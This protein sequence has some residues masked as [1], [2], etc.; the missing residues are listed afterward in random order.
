LRTITFKLKAVIWYLKRPRL[1]PQLIRKTASKLFLSKSPDTRKEA[2]HLCREKAITSSDA[3]ARITGVAMPEPIQTKYKDIFAAA[4]AAAGKCPV[5]M[6]SPGDLNI[7][8]WIAEHLKARNVVETGVA[9]GWSSLAILLSISKRK[10]SLLVSTDMPYLNLN[11]DRYVGCVVPS[12]LKRHWQIIPLADRDAIPKAL[13][14]FHQIDMCHYD[15]DKSYRG[16]MWAYFKLWNALRPGGCF[17]SDDISD[18][19]GFRDF[20]KQIGVNPIITQS[21]TAK[22][23]KY[24]GIL[25]KNK[26]G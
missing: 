8:Y 10:D 15:S 21:P 13:K 12:E 7:L 18:N 6:G 23:L 3:I 22:G 5:K 19:L 24:V 2:E 9:Y 4:E 16:R 26:T 20:C 1:Y 25:F 11:N 14:Q 17:I